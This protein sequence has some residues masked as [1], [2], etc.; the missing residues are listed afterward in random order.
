MAV[1]GDVVVAALADRDPL[2]Q[3]VAAKQRLAQREQRLAAQLDAETGAHRAVAAVAADEVVAAQQALLAVRRSGCGRSRPRRPGRSRASSCPKRTR[4]ARRALG[5]AAQQ[6]LEGVL[7][8]QLV[9]L[10]RQRAVVGLAD[11]GLELVDRRIAVVHER[12][13]HE[14]LARRRTRPSA[15]RRRSRRRGSRRRCRAAGSSPSCARCSAPSSAAA[16]APAA[17][18]PARTS[19]PAGPAR[20]PASAP[21]VRRRR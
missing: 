8:D 12:R 5:D 2:E 10:Q 16:P 13:P 3:V 15:G 21:P 6:R 19:L 4:D 1:V 20:S 17:C 7:R 14:R 9:G 18:R 11:A